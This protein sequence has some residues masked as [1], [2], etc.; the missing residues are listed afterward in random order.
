MAK[1][2]NPA[3]DQIR[4]SA[5]TMRIKL[6]EAHDEINSIEYERDEIVDKANKRI[7]KIQ[8]RIVQAEKELADYDKAI[9][10]LEALLNETP[11]DE[12]VEAPA[13]E[14]DPDNVTIVE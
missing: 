2:S 1:K 3:L 12:P 13:P 9:E 10:T 11:I 14:D 8:K 7:D 4:A 6:Q 5:G